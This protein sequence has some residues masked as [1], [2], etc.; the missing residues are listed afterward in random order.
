M[1]RFKMK[2]DKR[3]IFLIMLLITALMIFSCSLF[4]D[5]AG[6]DFEDKKTNEEIIPTYTLSGRLSTTNAASPGT[7]GYVVVT[8]SGGSI[9]GSA[10]T[11]TVFSSSSPYRADYTISGI[12]AG[13]YV[14]STFIDLDGNTGSSY[15]PDTGDLYNSTNFA[16]SGNDTLN[17]TGWVV[18]P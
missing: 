14:F 4:T 17:C 1:R 12:R 7:Y 8:T 6:N 16:I 13:S 11:L 10:R 2:L 3:F 15:V 5:K 18:Y 9:V